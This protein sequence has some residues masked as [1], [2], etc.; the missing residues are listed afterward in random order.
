MWTM[1]LLAP[2]YAGSID[3]TNDSPAVFAEEMRKFDVAN[4]AAE[5]RKSLQDEIERLKKLPEQE[6]SVAY[7]MQLDRIMSLLSG[8]DS[9]L[10]PRR[11]L[12]DA[13]LHAL[14]SFNAD[15]IDTL[16]RDLI[17]RIHA[18]FPGG[19]GAIAAERLEEIFVSGGRAYLVNVMTQLKKDA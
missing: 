5:K 2:T 3:T 7:M 8:Y 4:P 6:R 16:Y 13:M 15:P 12:L 14:V 10:D 11:N 17:E 19:H 18:I 1:D 9:F